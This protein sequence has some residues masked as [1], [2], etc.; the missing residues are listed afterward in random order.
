MMP[1]VSPPQLSTAEVMEREEGLQ[2][3]LGPELPPPSPTHPHP[4]LHRG[5]PLSI[6]LSECNSFLVK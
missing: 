6:P 1:Q 3:A 2:A 5:G 4:C